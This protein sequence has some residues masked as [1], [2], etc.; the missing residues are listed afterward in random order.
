YTPPPVPGEEDRTPILGHLV[1][2]LQGGGVRFA[3]VILRS[4]QPHL[5]SLLSANQVKGVLRP[6]SVSPVS[7]LSANQF[8]RHKD[9]DNSYAMRIYHGCDDRSATV[10][11]QRPPPEP[12]DLNSVTV[13]EGEPALSMVT[14]ESGSCRTED[15]LDTVTGIYNDAQDGAV[16]KGNVDSTEVEPAEAGNGVDDGTESSS[17]VGA[18]AK[19]KRRRI[20][21]GLDGTPRV[22]GGGLRAQEL[23]CVSPIVSK[24]PP[25]MAAVLSWW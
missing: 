21:A 12:P 8:Q 13:G 11:L 7:L 16:T 14:T 19:K 2:G 25:L 1:I 4:P 23:C 5:S 6:Q 20:T 15:L 22:T 10:V 3:V 9:E 18:S 17:E 24:P